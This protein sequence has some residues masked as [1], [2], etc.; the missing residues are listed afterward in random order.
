MNVALPI[1]CDVAI[2][3]KIPG[4]P[5]DQVRW[6]LVFGREIFEISRQVVQA[7]SSNR[8]I[9]RFATR[10]FWK[11]FQKFNIFFAIKCNSTRPQRCVCRIFLHRF[12]AV[13]ENNSVHHTNRRK[14]NTPMRVLRFEKD[15]FGEYPWNAITGPQV[16]SHD[17]LQCATAVF[18]LKSVPTMTG[19]R[20]HNDWFR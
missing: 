16:F 9:S 5:P 19:S 6:A 2:R 18:V 4:K 7:Y 13:P 20:V 10:S 8:T 17:L 14:G 11:P 3:S 12:G 15:S 1:G